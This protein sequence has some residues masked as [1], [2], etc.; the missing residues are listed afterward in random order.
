MDS[1]LEVIGVRTRQ[2]VELGAEDSLR[3]WSAIHR[4]QPT[5][6]Q[7]TSVSASVAD[8]ALG[9]ELEEGVEA[10]EFADM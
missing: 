10:T 8:S 9:D 4:S 3:Q 6:S 7:A 2:H 1:V 5:E